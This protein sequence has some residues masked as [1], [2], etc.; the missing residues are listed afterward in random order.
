MQPNTLPQKAASLARA[1]PE[2]WREFVS[3]FAEFNELHRDNLT[4]SALPELPVNQGRAQM[5]GI[6]YEMMAKALNAG[7]PN[8]D[9]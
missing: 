6:I 4:R 5:V 9:K 2:Q 8:K 7:Q 3:A 1:A